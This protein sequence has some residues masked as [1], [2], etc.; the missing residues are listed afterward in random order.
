MAEVIADSRASARSVRFS[1]E[2]ART[3]AVANVPFLFSTRQRAS[4]RN[5]VSSFPRHSMEAAHRFHKC[6]VL[7]AYVLSGLNVMVNVVPF[8]RSSVMVPS[9]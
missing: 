2:T 7:G 8:V 1:S 9:S 6:L 3:V 4:A 5:S